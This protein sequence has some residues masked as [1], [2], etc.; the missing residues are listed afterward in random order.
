MLTT[1]TQLSVPKYKRKSKARVSQLLHFTSKFLLV[2]LSIGVA[3]PLLSIAQEAPAA[4]APSPDSG[5]RLGRQYAELVA[6]V[7]RL[8]HRW[9]L[10][11]DLGVRWS[12]SPL[13]PPLTLALEELET[14]SD[15]QCL[16]LAEA[17]IR[18][19]PR[20]FKQPEEVY[21]TLLKRL[22][23]KNNNT[24]LTLA[25]TSAA[26][27]IHPEQEFLER[28]WQ[29]TEEDS[30]RQYIERELARTPSSIL[31]QKWREN[32]GSTNLADRMLAVKG[33]GDA[34]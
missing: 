12:L 8:V 30:V 33:V 15:R 5:E 25:L 13:P 18:C 4:T 31:L 20:G 6:E 28:L 34:P 32:L 16:Q 10:E 19:G 24:S 1:F 7:P 27:R 23:K 2:S 11:P 29:L 17:I 21:Q 9:E 14:G 22:Q 26:I 3:T